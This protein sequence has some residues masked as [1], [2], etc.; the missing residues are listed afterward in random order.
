MTEHVI[1]VNEHDI[2]IGTMPKL[3]A[4]QKGILH[5]AFSVFIFNSKGEM[6]L[7]QRAL[8]KY[9]SAGLWSNACCSHPLPGEDTLA[10][11]HRRLMEEMGMQTNLQQVYSF[12]YKVAL[13]NNLTEHEFDHVFW[14]V[15]DEKP[16]INKNETS[17]YKYVSVPQLRSTIEQTPK[18]YTEWFKICINDLLDKIYPP[19]AYNV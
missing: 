18:V 8:D 13:E 5:R 19:F 9:H 14:G 12:I 4:H 10:A 2:E 16:N 3:E 17:G 6:L 11:A 15:S 7:Q 1:L